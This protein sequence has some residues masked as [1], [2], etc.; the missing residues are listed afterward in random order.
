MNTTF[1]DQMKTDIITSNEIKTKLIQ[2]NIWNVDKFADALSKDPEIDSV[3]K[4][5]NGDKLF[6]RMKQTPE[7]N[8]LN[9]ETYSKVSKVAHDM[10]ASNKDIV[11]TIL[12]DTEK[13]KLEPSLN[14]MY[15][16]CLVNDNKGTVILDI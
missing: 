8:K 14:L 15:S 4:T 10:I 7:C 9:I 13:D 5:P 3:N 6:L 12:T 2:N 16:I 1:A 11:D